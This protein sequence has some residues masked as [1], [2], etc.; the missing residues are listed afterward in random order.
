ME[1]SAKADLNVQE[2]FK[3]ASEEVLKKIESGEINPLNDVF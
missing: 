3:K 1:V 2:V